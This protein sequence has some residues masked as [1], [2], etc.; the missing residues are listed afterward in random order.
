M[1]KIAAPRVSPNRWPHAL[2]TCPSAPNRPRSGGGLVEVRGGEGCRA[3]E[4]RV[5]NRPAAPVSRSHGGLRPAADPEGLE[6]TTGRRRARTRRLM[7]VVPSERNSRYRTKSAAPRPRATDSTVTA[8]RKAARS[9]TYGRAR[10]LGSQTGTLNIETRATLKFSGAPRSAAGE[11][12][13]GGGPTKVQ[14][15]EIDKADCGNVWTGA[16]LL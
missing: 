4:R 16:D 7:S 11:A 3:W 10:V 2:L 1:A 6:N 15:A 13:V 8:M 14:R 9:W 5:G 12:F